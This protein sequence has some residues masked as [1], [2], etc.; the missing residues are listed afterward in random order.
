MPA[1]LVFLM[2]VAFCAFALGAV[3]LLTR[4]MRAEA[5]R[6]VAA[7]EAAGRRSPTEAT[8]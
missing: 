1:V 3:L 8:H 7:R 5:D 6:V 2:V 4:A